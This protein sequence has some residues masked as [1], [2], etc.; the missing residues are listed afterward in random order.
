MEQHQNPEGHVQQVCPVEDLKE[1][2]LSRGSFGIRW[3]SYHLKATSSSDERL[4]AHKHDEQDSEQEE[5]RGICTA[6]NDAVQL[7]LHR[8]Q[9]RG[10]RE[11]LGIQNR[12]AHH[13]N[14]WN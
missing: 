5:T 8:K 14:R 4:R 13:I 9:P 7:G 3:I 1:S 11:I 6:G 12:I 2:E 10:G